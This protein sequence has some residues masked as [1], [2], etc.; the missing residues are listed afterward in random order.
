MVKTLFLR[1]KLC[2]ALKVTA[3]EGVAV[4]MSGDITRP[5]DLQTGLDDNST[6]QGAI[7]ALARQNGAGDCLKALLT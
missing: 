6:T 7:P 3:L 4:P 2:N 5:R 1:V